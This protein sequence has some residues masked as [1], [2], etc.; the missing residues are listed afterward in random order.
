MGYIYVEFRSKSPSLSKN[1]NF[2][3]MSRVICGS[4]TEKID[5]TIIIILAIIYL[6]FAYFATIL[7]YNIKYS[8]IV[9]ANKININFRK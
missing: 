3:A 8:D 5:N 4:H 9:N 6:F 2:N 1:I 7:Y